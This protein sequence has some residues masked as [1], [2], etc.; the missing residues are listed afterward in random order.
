MDGLVLEVGA[1]RVVVSGDD[2]EPLRAGNGLERR[3]DHI[4]WAEHAGLGGDDE[5]RVGLIFGSSGR[6]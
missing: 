3:V 5:H 4:G 1:G 6:L 2:R